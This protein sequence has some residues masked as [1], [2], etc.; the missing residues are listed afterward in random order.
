MGLFKSSLESIVDSVLDMP[1][2]SKRLSEKINSLGIPVVEKHD[3]YSLKNNYQLSELSLEYDRKKIFNVIPKFPVYRLSKAYERNYSINSDDEIIKNNEKV[4]DEFF[5]MDREFISCYNDFKSLKNPNNFSSK[6]EYVEEFSKAIDRL[7]EYNDLYKSLKEK[8]VLTG[9]V[10]EYRVKF[11]LEEFLKPLYGYH[12]YLSEQIEQLK[13]MG[14]KEGVE[15]AIDYLEHEKK[16]LEKIMKKYDTFK[17][18]NGELLSKL[19]KGLNIFEYG[20]KESKKIIKTV[21]K[22][23]Y[24]AA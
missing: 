6:K 7:F 17:T 22:F 10:F 5:R 18:K 21:A 8:G 12:S 3:G 19:K 20:K 9:P 16:R 24:E 15:N 14:S 13:S 1:N 23:L 2:V 4:L 11:N